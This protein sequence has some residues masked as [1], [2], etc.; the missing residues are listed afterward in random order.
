MTSD[1]QQYHVELQWL[2]IVMY[3]CA[4]KSIML[5][6]QNDFKIS[7]FR[8][9]RTHKKQL[10]STARAVANRRYQELLSTPNSEEDAI[11]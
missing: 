1:E 9:S 10:Q 6:P 4:V 8:C 5:C 11:I 7:I 3:P 2:I